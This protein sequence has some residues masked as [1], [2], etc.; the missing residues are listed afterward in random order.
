MRGKALGLIETFGYLSA[1]EAAD[2]CLKTA[3][4]TLIGLEKVSGG[5][6][7]IK[8]SGDVA[9][10]K[11]AIDAAEVAVKEMGN[12][13]STHV[14]SRT[15][16]GLDKI[17]FSDICGIHKTQKKELRKS[18]NK[19]YADVD[20]IVQ[21]IR[22]DKELNE[23]LSNPEKTIEEL[24]AMKVVKLR[25]LARKMEGIKLD[26]GEIKFARKNQLIMA[27]LEFYERGGRTDD[28]R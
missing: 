6:V 28:S 19:D 25:T 13:L 7:T 5:L 1:V 11:V 12:L 17:I 2:I 26:K 15:A 9:A 8:I 3:N 24:K 4:V 10:V 18:M 23:N 21:E 16:E 22:I 20:T 27:I 14:I